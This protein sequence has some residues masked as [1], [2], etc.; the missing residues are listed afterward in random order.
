MPLKTC[1]GCGAK[2]GPRT[3]KCDCG[4]V[5]GSAISAVPT[6][7]QPEQKVVSRGGKLMSNVISP[8]IGYGKRVE[9]YPVKL[10]GCDDE[11][12]RS[13]LVETQAIVNERSD[14]YT[15]EAFF[16]MAI[17]HYEEEGVVWRDVHRKINEQY[18][19]LWGGD[20]DT[21]ADIVKAKQERDELVRLTQGQ[22]KPEPKPVPKPE[23]VDT[24]LDMED[25]FA[26]FG[27]KP[28]V[29]PPQ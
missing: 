6:Q 19:T 22:K 9:I 29:I 11:S 8:G 14:W 12:I 1:P 28:A 3:H 18:D 27:I 13:W 23:P 15:C 25:I 26:D 4:H 24:E 20:G 17:T 2:H 7:N 5:F 21:L 10:R 16:S